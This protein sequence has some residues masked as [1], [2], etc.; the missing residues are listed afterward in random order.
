MSSKIEKLNDVRIILIILF[1][2]IMLF[3]VGFLIFFL[4]PSV[5]SYKECLQE[6][7]QGNDVPRRSCD[8]EMVQKL[9]D[10]GRCWWSDMTPILD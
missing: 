9:I 7:N 8:Y 3:V 2:L 5:W 1:S 10:H 4:G 6:C